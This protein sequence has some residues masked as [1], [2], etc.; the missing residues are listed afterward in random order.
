MEEKLEKK[1]N[2]AAAV[3][4]ILGI[5]AGICFILMAIEEVMFVYALEGIVIAFAGW[6]V[7][8][9]IQLSISVSKKLSALIGL[10]RTYSEK[11]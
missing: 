2:F 6:L 5:I 3:I 4:L 8:L 9:F 10:L 1:L 11:H 7:N